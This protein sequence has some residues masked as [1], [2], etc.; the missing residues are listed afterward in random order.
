MWRWV[1]FTYGYSLLAAITFSIIF[2]VSPQDGLPNHLPDAIQIHTVPFMMLQIAVCLWEFNAV[3]W[4]VNFGWK[5]CGFS[6]RTLKLSWV[7]A[8]VLVGLTA[9]KF[10]NDFNSITK[11]APGAGEKA[12]GL[13]WKP[14]DEP[15]ASFFGIVDK[16]WFALAAVLPII[17]NVWLTFFY[18]DKL[19]LFVIDLTMYNPQISNDNLRVYLEDGI[20]PPNP[21][22]NAGHP[23]EAACA[24][25]TTV[26]A[27][28]S[29]DELEEL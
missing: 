25:A 1:Q 17:T 24:T 26:V 2:A 10:L 19:P 3:W 5:K 11:P 9:F 27:G 22:I 6:E 12:P 29:K 15:M 13:M 14:T 16:S 7:Y 18:A 21:W 23:K 8:Y 20:F 4:G 28:G